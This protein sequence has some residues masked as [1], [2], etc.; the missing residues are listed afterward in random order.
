M[1]LRAAL[2][3]VYLSSLGL[4]PAA[5]AAAHHRTKHHVVR[6]NA[7]KANSG[8]VHID[9]GD[10]NGDGSSDVVTAP[11]PKHKPK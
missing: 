1:K 3:I 10:V 2:A 6:K 8:G 7:K 4:T 11:P 9:S 5:Q